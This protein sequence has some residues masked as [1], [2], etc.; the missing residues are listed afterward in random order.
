MTLD[1]NVRPA[2]EGRAQ[3]FLRRLLKCAVITKSPPTA[4]QDLVVHPASK[5]PYPQ[6]AYPYISSI[7]LLETDYC[8]Y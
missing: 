2:A 7:S 1:V 8:K 3:D 4:P 6:P 5:K